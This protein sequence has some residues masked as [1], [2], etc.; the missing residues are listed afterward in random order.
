MTNRTLH[1]P[2]LQTYKARRCSTVDDAPHQAVHNLILVRFSTTPT[3][4]TV[5]ISPVADTSKIA[6]A[7]ASR[8]RTEQ[9]TKRGR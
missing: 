1:A 5:R 2:L 6:E 9:L 8:S 7:T 4:D 3:D